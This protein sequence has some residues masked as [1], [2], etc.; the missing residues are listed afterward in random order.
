MRT[1]QSV[2]P[3][4][5]ALAVGLVFGSIGLAGALL[6]APAFAQAAAAHRFAIAAG[7]LATALNQIGATTG[8]LLSFDP[9]LVSGRQS[10]A[11][12]GTYSA[13]EALYRVLQGSG[14]EASPR[15][16]GGYTVRS[17][18]SAQ[19]PQLAPVNV[20]ATLYG[21]RE[22]NAL[23]DSTASVG[24]VTAE[25]LENGSIRTF[26]ESFRLLGNV[27][28]SA[29]VNSG[30]VI[31]GMSSEG[32]V[33]GGSPLASL[34]VDGVLQTRTNSRRAPRS[35]WDVEQVEV[36]RGPQS[37]LSGSAAMIGAIYIKSKDPTFEREAAISAVAGNNKLAGG[38]FMVNAPVIPGQLAVRLTG[39][40]ERSK[41]TVDMPTYRH[42]KHYDDY[43]TDLSH[44]LRGKVLFM[45]EAL[46]NTSVLFSY[47]RGK[48][49]PVDRFV[50]VGPGF[51]F[52]DER[53]DFYQF[54]TYAE[55]RPINTQNAGLEIKHDFTDRLQL[56]A[57]TGWNEGKTK[58]I[59]IDL[60]TPGVANGIDGFIDDALLSQE[61][62]MNYAGER[63]KWVAGIYA[64]QQKND[65]GLFGRLAP[66]VYQTQ[67]SSLRV[68]NTAL[69][70]E[71]TY[72]FVPDWFATL[73]GRIDRLRQT[74]RLNSTIVQGATVTNLDDRGS[75]DEVNFVPKV[76]LA[77][78]FGTSHMAGV[79]YS[80][81]F[82]SGG[83]YLN[84]RTNAPGFYDPEKAHSAELFYKGL[85][86]SERLTLNA[87]LFYTRYQD[88]QIE[89]RPDPN[90]PFYRE[91]QNA[92][93]SRTWGLEIEPVWRVTPR[94]TTFASV[95][96]LKTE[97]LD[98]NHASY[99]D[100][101]GQ[102]LPEAP[103][104]ALGLGGHYQFD[105]G[106]YIGADA[107]YTA[108]YRAQFGIPPQDTLPARTIVNLQAGLRKD[109]WE[110][111]AFAE[112]LFDKRYFTGIDA[113]ATPAFGQ[114]GARR[115]VGVRATMTF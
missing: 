23:N 32:F 35:T 9:P 10:P 69:F 106:F 73:G 45:P 113:D 15:T 22:T 19:G 57:N 60:G 20:T 74:S 11:L 7:P 86:L 67:S 53:G 12:N 97:F 100:M 52:K 81:G 27:M 3:R 56:T 49:S 39:S 5:L 88:Q 110:I 101:S 66:T 70:G 28:D 47:A 92:A 14:L 29:Y 58:R 50:G 108:R 109:N 16:D 77:R 107:K 96:Y 13:D 93:A 1:P 37:T 90:D 76:A 40:Y 82:R 114:I 103:K 44:N 63:W 43:T 17:L 31:R 54:P 62:R 85:L 95:G 98:F 2:S 71:A 104:W 24:V 65:S 105:N 33:P 46:P 99:G 83:H 34:Y 26:R 42:F 48:E 38:D 64:S 115:S 59:S 87:N 18:S 30:F 78:K 79:S 61:V 80:Q 4:P 102:P 8:V 72:E 55:N 21:S 111:S 6:P 91:T 41:T 89:I 36:Y 75:I 112:N 68:T 84:R 94:F 25:Q 51:S